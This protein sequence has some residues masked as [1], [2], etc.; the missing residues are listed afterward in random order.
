MGVIDLEHRLRPV[1]HKLRCISLGP[2]LHETIEKTYNRWLLIRIFS[3]GHRYRG[4][5]WWFIPAS[6]CSKATS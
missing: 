3:Q 2:N 6:R 5:A 1:R 4:S